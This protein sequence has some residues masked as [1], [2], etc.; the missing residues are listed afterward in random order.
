[1]SERIDAVRWVRRTPPWVVVLVGVY[2]AGLL[3]GT[4]THVSDLVRHGLHPYAWAPDWLNLYWTA[5]AFLDPLAA[6]LLVAGRPRGLDLACLIVATDLAANFYATYAIQHLDVGSAPG[7]Q[8]L[9]V[10]TLLLLATA[11]LVRRHLAGTSQ[12]PRRA[13]RRQAPPAPEDG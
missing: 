9:T 13:G 6:V 1:M 10:F 5:L 4:V 2:A 7:L 11:P 3:V 8:R 12:A